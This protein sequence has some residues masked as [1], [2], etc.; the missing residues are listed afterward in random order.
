MR[1][2]LRYAELCVREF[3][4]TGSVRSI[5]LGVVIALFFKCIGALLNPANRTRGGFRWL[6]MTHTVAMFFFATIYF[7]VNLNLL[8]TAYI[9][10]REFPGI[11]VVP[12][13]PL[14][15]MYNSYNNAAGVVSTVMFLLNNWLADGLLVNLLPGLVA[16]I[17]D[18]GCSFSSIVAM[19]YT[20]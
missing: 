19:L 15:Y 12:P 20:P 10:N 6:L 8:S 1:G 5:I 17:S 7:A 14:G 18:A 9:D 4:L 2:T 3:S 11:N 13:G 16:Q